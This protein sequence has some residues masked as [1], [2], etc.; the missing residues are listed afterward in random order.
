MHALPGCF[1][2]LPG[3]EIRALALRIRRMNLT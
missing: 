3:H 1:M 2:G